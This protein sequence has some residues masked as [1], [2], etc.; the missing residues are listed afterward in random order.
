[1]K[2]MNILKEINELGPT[3]LGS[4]SSLHKPGLKLWLRDFIKTYKL[5]VPSAKRVQSQ[6]I[7]RAIGKDKI[8]RMYR[9]GVEPY[10]AAKTFITKVST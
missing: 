3:Q 10:R 4:R 5:I 1:M 7:L 6:D 9:R 8:L 2:L